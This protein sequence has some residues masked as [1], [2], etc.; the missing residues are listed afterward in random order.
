MTQSRAALDQAR[1]D[2][3]AAAAAIEVA[4]E[5]ARRVETLLGYTKIEAPFDGIVTQRNV[6][7]GQLDPAGQRRRPAVRRRPVRYRDHPRRRPR[8]VRRCGRA[9]RPR[10]PSHSRR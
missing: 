9:R 5:D 7:T 6:D 2:V 1:S 10:R 8:D 4:K 3:A